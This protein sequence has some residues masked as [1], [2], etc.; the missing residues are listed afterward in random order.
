MPPS[1]A[2][3]SP[4]RHT[5]TSECAAAIQCHRSDRTTDR[6]AGIGACTAHA[7]AHPRRGPRHSAAPSL[8]TT[9]A[10]CVHSRVPTQDRPC[11]FRLRYHLTPQYLVGGDT[12]GP[13]PAA[14]LTTHAFSVLVGG[15]DVLRVGVERVG[16]NL[17]YGC[18]TVSESV[19]ALDC[20]GSGA[21]LVGTLYASIDRCPTGAGGEQRPLTNTTQMAVLEWFCTVSGDE[22]RYYV[23]L[24][25]DALFDA[26]GPVPG[27]VLFDGSRPD[28]ST[29]VPRPGLADN[30]LKEARGYFRVSVDHREFDEG[31]I[32]SGESREGCVSFGQWRRFTVVTS[33]PADAS[34]YLSSAAVAADG[35]PLGRSAF[36]ALYVRRNKEATKDVHDVAVFSP[37]ERAARATPRHATARHATPRHATARHAT[38]RHGAPRH[39]APRHG[40]PRR[41]TAPLPPSYPECGRPLRARARAETSLS[42]SPCYVDD[43][44]EYHISS[45][46]ATQLRATADGLAP[47]L[48]TLT[49]RL[50]PA[51][52]VRY[53]GPG[54]PAL[55]AT[56]LLTLPLFAG[57]GGHVCCHQFRYWVL[58]AIPP[59]IEPFL[60]INM[61]SDFLGQPSPPPGAPPPLPSLPPLPPTVVYNASH[62]LPP[63]PP[64]TPMPPPPSPPPVSAGSGGGGIG[65]SA[66]SV[67]GS[68]A[69]GLFLKRGTCPTPAD[70][71][72]NSACS[73]RCSLSWLVRYNVYSGQQSYLSSTSV[74]G[75]FAP[76]G[77][78]SAPSDWYVGVQSL[79]DDSAEF[80][81]RVGWRPRPRRVVAYACNRLNHFC[82]LDGGVKSIDNASIP[83]GAIDVSGAESLTSGA[84]AA[85]PLS[86][87]ALLLLPSL[88]CAL[89][90]LAR[91]PRAHGRGLASRIS[92]RSSM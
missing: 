49:P 66:A 29:V 23:A 35:N 57:G 38:P 45:Y 79:R 89:L 44:Y 81:L 73:G 40:A 9:S 64:P 17:T 28:D 41:A 26:A 54:W 70:I 84:A 69:Q 1:R 19:G 42:T 62:P 2:A 32:A 4:Y 85:A 56:T 6:C 43:P 30:V 52:G 72:D 5:S 83:A 67:S 76:L 46:L 68:H 77:E 91:G 3:R 33:G 10:R 11:Q 58:R 65:G 90:L 22:G 37:G 7:T 63:T 27:Y 53:G 13:L 12:L 50:L 14:P 61:S 25:T 21:G 20:L 88:C 48:F 80:T 78:E 92:R 31:P 8:F 16:R 75:G 51:E 55:G 34:L 87:R 71:V 60:I 86:T 39:G 74:G 47:A 24:T 36:S 59:D 15:Y 82:P 18:R